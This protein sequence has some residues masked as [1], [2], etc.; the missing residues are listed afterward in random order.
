MPSTKIRLAL[1]TE[2][3]AAA[4]FA[5]T[6]GT[7]IYFNLYRAQSQS[8]AFACAPPDPVCVFLEI[9]MI[10][11]IDHRLCWFLE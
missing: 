10:R 8:E 5:V 3:N 11:F 4:R 7:Y 9:G 1:G 6:F 2:A